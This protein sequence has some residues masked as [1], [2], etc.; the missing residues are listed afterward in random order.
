[1]RFLLRVMVWAL[2][3]TNRKISENISKKHFKQ[4]LEDLFNLSFLPFEMV[5][6]CIFIVKY[7][8]VNV[9]GSFYRVKI[10]WLL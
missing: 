3:P 4:D 1:M 2:E 8:I 7:I 9:R 10:Q 5:L 6:R